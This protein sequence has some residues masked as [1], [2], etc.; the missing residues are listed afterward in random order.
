VLLQRLVCIYFKID[1]YRYITRK[2]ALEG[3]HNGLNLNL[4]GCS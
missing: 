2:E 4:L 3:R 1:H